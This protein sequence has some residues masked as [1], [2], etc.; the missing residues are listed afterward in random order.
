VLPILKGVAYCACPLPLAAEERERNKESKQQQ[1][2]QQQ[3]K[4]P[5]LMSDL[6]VHLSPNS[7]GE[8]VKT[9]E[10][11]RSF[12]ADVLSKDEQLLAID[13][14][15][16]A[17]PEAEDNRVFARCCEYTATFSAPTPL[18]F[19][20]GVPALPQSLQATSS[21]MGVE[22][23][24]QGELQTAKPSLQRFIW[25]CIRAHASAG[26]CCSAVSSFVSMIVLPLF[27]K[28]FVNSAQKGDVVSRLQV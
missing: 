5:I 16:G 27:V 4:Q 7:N 21:M 12:H 9:G 24:W 23:L 20:E 10:K 18:K 17:S 3:S 8:R 14:I 11:R 2:K 13:A 28:A 19:V 22:A 26:L 6:D 15:R 25:K 1:S